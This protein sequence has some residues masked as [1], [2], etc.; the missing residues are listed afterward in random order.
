MRN[1]PNPATLYAAGA[2]GCT[3]DPTLSA[4]PG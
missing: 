4:I 1:V 2:E 3:D